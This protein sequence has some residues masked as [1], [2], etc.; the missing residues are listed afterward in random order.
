M[1]VREGKYVVEINPERTDF[2]RYADTSIH[3]KA[4]VVLPMLVEEIRSIKK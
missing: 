1:A 3:G 2:T 4:G